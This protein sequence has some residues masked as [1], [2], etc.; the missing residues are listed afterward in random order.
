MNNT[1]IISFRAHVN[2]K[3]WLATAAKFFPGHTPEL[4]R[5]ILVKAAYEEAVSSGLGAF[6]GRLVQGRQRSIGNS[7]V[8]S[9]RLPMDIINLIKGCAASKR[10]SL[11]EWASGVLFQWYEEQAAHNSEP[12]WLGQY[13]KLFPAKVNEAAAV[14]AGKQAKQAGRD[15]QSHQVGGIS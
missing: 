10:V 6:L 8:F 7:C 9:V 13:A 12:G 5:L 4:L 2:L 14:Y 3:S 1:A 11:S 15:S